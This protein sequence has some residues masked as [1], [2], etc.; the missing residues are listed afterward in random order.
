[1]YSVIN[2]LFNCNDFLWPLD[3]LWHPY[4]NRPTLTP[5]RRNAVFQSRHGIKSS[6]DLWFRIQLSWILPHQNMISNRRRVREFITE[7]A[8]NLGS[9]CSTVCQKE[10]CLLAYFRWQNGCSISSNVCTEESFM[11]LILTF[12]CRDQRRQLGC[13]DCFDF[14]WKESSM[15]GRHNAIAIAQIQDQC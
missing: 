1:M 10:G 5:A 7:Q 6:T 3:I 2:I 8:I 14:L 4:D 12:C 11:P 15:L 13:Q 9:S